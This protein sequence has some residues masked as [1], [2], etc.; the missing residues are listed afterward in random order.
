M[1]PVVTE[2]RPAA[3]E[4]EILGEIG[5]IRLSHPPV[6]ALG[7]AVRQG[8]VAAITR[9]LSDPCVKAIVLSGTGRAFSAGADLAEF[10][11]VAP[12]PTLPEALDVIAGSPKPVIA[13]L[14][15]VAFGGGLELAMAAQLRIG[16]PGLR[17][18]LPEV[19][20]GLIPGAG[21]TQRLPRLVGTA[22]AVEM[23]CSGRE[24]S[25]EEA[26]SLGL[27]DRLADAPPRE[28]G[29][30]AARAVLAGRLTPR[31]TDA[32]TAVADPEVLE[33]ARQKIIARKPVLAA[34]L[35][36][37]EAVY[38]AS[39]TAVAEG[40]AHERSAFLK[41]REGPDRQG[42]V[43]AFRAERATG[44][45][46]EAAGPARQ[47]D[48]VGVIGGGTMGVGIATAF[49]IAGL[50]VRLIETEAPRAETARAAI[51]RN[52]EG[53]L[54]RGK[55]DAAGHA[56]AVAG[57]TASTELA[58]LASVDL[59][60][61]AVFEDMA[62]KTALF[63]RLDRICGPATI[64]ATNTSYLDINRIAEA[65]GRPE[66]VIGLHFFSPAHVMRLLEVVVA[67]KTAPALVATAFALARRMGKIPVRS[68]VCD[69]FIG[70]RILAHFRKATEYLVLD[71]AGFAQVDRALEDVG[72]AMGPYAVSDLAGL[73]IGL[74]TRRRK[75][76]TRPVQERYS[77]VADRICEAGW[78][79]R[80]TG[81]GFYLYEDGRRGAVNPGADQILA[82]ERAAAG[83]TIRTVTAQEIVD[84]CMTAMISEAVRVLDEGIALRPID[85]DAV[86]L[87]G[88]GFPRH[89][90]GPMHLADRI[91]AAELL[92]RI[93]TYAE[94][95]RHFWQ[96]P[97][98]LRR[99]AAT[100][101]TFAALNEG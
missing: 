5:V 91:G 85:I 70:N 83:I 50:P 52:L 88:Y 21:G 28:A 62:V 35:A 46:P 6:N 90:G 33:A 10:G 47:I 56:A 3:V 89:L 101:E 81:R 95:D 94:E 27:L 12:P 68:G 63:G 82:E 24:V 75:A 41:L 86:K 67:D 14:H 72:F 39:E 65:T 96:V 57:L 32:V 59:V 1:S 4:S 80:K 79:G 42:L 100:G 9:L 87:F 11:K 49:L 78:L 60:V 25:A 30:A 20:L 45:I 97:E 84:R 48:T 71:G 26:L 74:M 8:L 92:R 73:D 18:A 19:K 98:R 69:G 77:R 37:L 66:A 99:M 15:G 55:L 16:L 40:M 44:K 2:T 51:L 29:L 76:A 54:R 34:P 23:I 93:E 43:H 38:L 31:H 22:A 61:E 7:A 58:S 17:L 13:V 36:A 53:A 64:L